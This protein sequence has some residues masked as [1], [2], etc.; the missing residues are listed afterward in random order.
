MTDSPD[1]APR[2]PRSGPGHPPE[3]TDPAEPRRIQVRDAGMMRALAH[4]VRLRLLGLLRVSGPATVGMLAEQVGESAGT[5]S[6][7]VQTLAKHGFV[8]EAPGLAR[9]RRERWWRAA[10]DVTTSDAADLL[11]DPEAKAAS[12]EYRRTVIDSYRRELLAAIDAEAGLE[13]EWVAASDSSDAVAH[14]TLEE[15]RNVGAELAAVRE[16]W[17]RR[18]RERRTGTRAVRV[19]THVFPRSGP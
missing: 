14:L 5:V 15:F 4:P 3:P 1:D 18:G 16:K 9:D 13:P 11:G 2:R 8:V 19:I 17:F 10:H 12:D 6:Y 7:H